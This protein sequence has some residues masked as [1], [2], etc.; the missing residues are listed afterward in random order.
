M[1]VVT[2]NVPLYSLPY[3]GGDDPIHPVSLAG[4][5]ITAGRLTIGLRNP[6]RT[7]ADGRCSVRPENRS[8][9]LLRQSIYRSI[10]R[11]VGF[12]AASVSYRS[13]SL[14]SRARN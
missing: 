14:E 6:G 5:T 7:P 8:I 12:L 11:S 2:G 9:E 4:L 13:I 10:L 3:S 1:E